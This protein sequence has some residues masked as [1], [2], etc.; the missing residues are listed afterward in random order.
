[1]SIYSEATSKDPFQG[2]YP[3]TDTGSDGLTVCK[4]LQSRGYIT[5]YEWAFGFQH[6]LSVISQYAMMQGTEWTN[7]MFHPEADGRVHPEGSVAGGHEYVW[8]GVEIVSKLD[9]TQNRSWFLNSWGNS[10]GV[11]GYFYMTWPDHEALLARNGDL[12]CPRA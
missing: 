3:P 1:V 12:G 8:V 10:F 7:A 11:N 2:Q 4:V 9:S 5:S 6:G